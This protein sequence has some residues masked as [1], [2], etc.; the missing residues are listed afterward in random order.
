MLKLWIRTF[1]KEFY[2]Q[3]AGLLLVIF[4]LLFGWM[5][6]GEVF[7]YIHSILLEFC[8]SSIAI[9]SF[10]F[11]LLLYGLKS[12]AFIN[13]KLSIPVYSFVKISCAAKKIDQFKSWL[14]LYCVLLFPPLFFALLI[15]T[16]GLFYQ[17]YSCVFSLCLYVILLLGGLTQVT[18][19]QVNYAF[20]PVRDI[21]IP[22]PAVK[23]PFWTW[24]V[25]Y[26]LEKQP[27]M[28]I[29]CKIVS[30]LLFSGI[31]WMFADSRNDIRVYLIAMLGAAISHSILI[32]AVLRFERSSLTL[33]NSLPISNWKKL[34]NT[35][36]FL[37][38]LFAPEFILFSTKAPLS[39]YTIGTV[40]L[41]SISS[42]IT[43]KIALYFLKDNMDRYLKFIFFFFLVSMLFILINQFLLFSLVL[44]VYN[45]SY[46]SYLF[47]TNKL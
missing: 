26:L 29:I 6:S 36:L 15:C 34:L 9:L 18:F 19:R 22:W 2:K 41:Y 28:L 39:L 13:Q 45:S 30:F 32:A 24:P 16:T 43:L 14:G 17:Y 5:K 42:L 37:V 35:F 40:F 3:H 38:I 27:L 47:Y 25:H 4:Y 10:C 21:I 8:S 23:K 44:I 33:L 1:G 11:F 20:K 7:V 31:I 46:H 12:L